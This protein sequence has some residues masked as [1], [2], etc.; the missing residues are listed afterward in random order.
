M[1]TKADNTVAVG[2]GQELSQER[3]QV[4]G[5]NDIERISRQDVCVVAVR[6][7]LLDLG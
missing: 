5:W 2:H 6:F 1:P 7:E 4:V 3:V